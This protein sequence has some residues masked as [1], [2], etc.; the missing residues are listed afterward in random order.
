MSCHSTAEWPLK[1]PLI[2][3]FLPPIGTGSDPAYTGLTVVPRPGSPEF[4]RWFQDRPGTQPF[5]SGTTALDYDL[6]I[7]I[8]ALPLWQKWYNST[9]PIHPDTGVSQLPELLRQMMEKPESTSQ[10]GRRLRPS[11]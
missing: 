11:N 8:K 2:P 5:D 6:N 9:H 1:S 7:A 3:I 4:N 10:N